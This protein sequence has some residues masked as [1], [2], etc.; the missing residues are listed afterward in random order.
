MTSPRGTSLGR[1]FG[2]DGRELAW[3]GLCETA[4]SR[5]RG[6]QGVEEMGFGECLLLVPC[7]SIHT[8]GMKMDIDVACLDGDMRVI[9]MR[10]RLPPKKFL[11]TRRLFRTQSILEAAA[12]AFDAWDLKVGERLRLEREAS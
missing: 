6:L 10:P 3:V 12:G 11:L 9:A 7:R 5:A 8:W 4:R 1:L 2:E